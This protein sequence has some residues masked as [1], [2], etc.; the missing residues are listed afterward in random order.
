MSD[1]QCKKEEGCIIKC[2]ICHTWHYKEQPCPSL[3]KQLTGDNDS[4][5]Y[6]P[7]HTLLS[8]TE[9]RFYEALK[10]NVPENYQVFPQANLASFIDR[11]DNVRYRNELFRNIDFLITDEHFSPKLAVEINDQSHL[12]AQRRE[13][14]T[15]VRQILE[16]AG[17]PLMKLWTSYGI[18]PEYIQKTIAEKLNAP[19]TRKHHFS[20]NESSAEPTLS[21]TNT[22][23]KKQGCYVA[24]CVYGSYDCPQVWI[25]RRYRD[26]HLAATRH[27]RLCIWFYYLVSP[28]IVKAFGHITAFRK[29][30]QYF[31]DKKI[32]VLRKSGYADSSYRDNAY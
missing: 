31:L 28:W 19:V 1:L 20:L 7:R 27:G 22:G 3:T 12:D 25:L 6:E 8:Q 15:K 14:D 29:V 32:R 30:S 11:T 18:N 13:R 2:P 24:T 16:E 4:Y 21:S 10:N 23:K 9:Q 26:Y 5:L 17:I